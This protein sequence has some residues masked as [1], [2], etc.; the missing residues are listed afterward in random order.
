[1]RSPCFNSWVI[2]IGLTFCFC[3]SLGKPWSGSSGQKQKKTEMQ[4]IYATELQITLVQDPFLANFDVRLR[5]EKRSEHAN[6]ISQ[7]QQTEWHLWEGSQSHHSDVERGFRVS[8]KFELFHLESHS[9]FNSHRIL[10]KKTKHFNTISL[11]SA[12]PKNMATP[13]LP[14]YYGQR[15]RDGEIVQHP[16]RNEEHYDTADETPLVAPNLARPSSN[17]SSREK[18]R[19]NNPAYPA[20]SHSSPQQDGRGNSRHIRIANPYNHD[21]DGY[22]TDHS[23]TTDDRRGRPRRPMMKRL[24]SVDQVKQELRLPLTKWMNSNAKNRMLF[25]ILY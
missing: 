7:P 21:E 25:S 19:N 4:T 11:V 3:R 24:N 8:I 23:G 22:N 6:P 17:D 16:S 2:Q 18:S 13:E 1:M 20:P 12:W 15:T 9:N 14:S 10:T 5:G